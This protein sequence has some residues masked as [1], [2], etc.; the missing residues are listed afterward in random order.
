MLDRKRV[1]YSMEYLIS[2]EPKV[3]Y[4]VHHHVRVRCARRSAWPQVIE[5][6]INYEVHHHAR[7]YCARRSAWP[8]VIE[9]LINF[10][11]PIMRGSIALDRVLDLKWSRTCLYFAKYHHKRPIA[12]GGMFD[13]KWSKY[14]KSINHNVFLLFLTRQNAMLGGFPR[15][16]G[17]NMMADGYRAMTLLSPDVRL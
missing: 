8:Q 2:S 12:L 1:L 11:V 3:R 5:V 6:L 16:V 17:P 7:V 13:L 14:Y 10:E 15:H 4:E 9:V